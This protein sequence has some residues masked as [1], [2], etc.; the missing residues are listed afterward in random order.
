MSGGGGTVMTAGISAALSGRPDQNRMRIVLFMTDGY[1]GNEQQILELIDEQIGQ[2]RFFSL[3]VGSSVNRYLLD[4]MA[5]RGRGVVHYMDAG[6]EPTEEV[7]T[8]Y[9]RIRNPVLTDIEVDWGDQ[10]VFDVTPARVPDVFSGTPIQV[11]GRY[12]GPGRARVTIR[13]KQGNR[14]VSIPLTLTFP[15][16]SGSSN[17]PAVAHLWARRRIHELE[18]EHGTDRDAARQSVLPLA[19]RYGLLTAYTSFVAIEERVRADADDPLH[20]RGVPVALP[21]SMSDEGV[22]DHI[23]QPSADEAA[24]A[25]APQPQPATFGLVGTGRGGGG[26][27]QAIELGNTGT[28]GHG[29]GGGTGSGY[30]RGAGGLRGRRASAPRIHTGNATVTG[31]LSREVIQR[32]IRR[33]INQLRY[34]YEQQLAREPSLSGQVVVRFTISPHG[35]VSQA[36]IASTTLNNPTVEQCLLRAFRR[37]AFPQPAGGGVVVVSYP[38]TFNP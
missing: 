36:A 33:H 37:I 17:R 3:G 26:S 19:L 7:T 12:R 21:E 11:A 1:I 22:G 18:L 28:I 32:F 38:L 6:D 5:E 30:G 8:F 34:C 31:S 25:P 35:S 16:V 29:S 13:G 24:A 23:V 9:D 4:R 20:T 2:S 14:R 10:E 27:G 15:G